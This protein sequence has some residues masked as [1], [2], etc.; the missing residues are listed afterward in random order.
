MY[1][2]CVNQCNFKTKR[3]FTSC[4]KSNK[5]WQT[6][7]AKLLRSDNYCILFYLRDTSVLTKSGQTVHRYDCINCSTTLKYP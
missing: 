6:Q 5:I 4:R 7:L 3:I 1:V 2:F